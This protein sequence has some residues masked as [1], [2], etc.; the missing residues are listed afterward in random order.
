MYENLFRRSVGGTDSIVARDSVDLFSALLT[1]LGGHL[2]LA[3]VMIFGIGTGLSNIE[4]AV[5]Y[6]I[7]IESGQSLGGLGQVPKKN[8]S[9]VAPPKNVAPKPKESKEEEK[10]KIAV[11]EKAEVKD[12]K[13][14]KPEEKPK[15][16][17]KQ[18]SK[19][20]EPSKAEIDKRLQD[21]MQRY[22]GESSKAGGKGFG[23]A[24]LGGQEMGGGEVRPKEFFE[25]MEVLEERVKGGWHWYDQNAPLRA[26]V[27]FYISPNG[28]VS[29]ISIEGS[30]GNR[31][32]DDSVLRAVYKS[33]P[34]PPPPSIV[35][36]YFRS[37]R[38]IFDP[39]E[40]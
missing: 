26:S 29:G 1:S 35:Y 7:S 32:F 10:E 37:V 16:E 17:K 14:K 40:G 13:K 5:V 22:L 39:R 6:S 25:Y 36:Q 19:S 27:V 15:T 34:L 2:A 8:D 18:D 24:K 21:A 23:A 30:S 38:M 33:N 11:K 28:E 3:L 20:K 4:P 12:D 9:K 31:E